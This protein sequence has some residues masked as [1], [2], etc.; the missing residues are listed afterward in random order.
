M[1]SLEP[2]GLVEKLD[3]LAQGR[4]VVG[5]DELN[6]PLTNL[7]AIYP[8][9]GGAGLMFADL[10]TSVDIIFRV[11]HG[12]HSPSN[13]LVQTYCPDSNSTLSWMEF[14]VKHKFSGVHSI[15]KS[16]FGA[17]DVVIIC[18]KEVGFRI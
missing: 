12:L 4:R 5:L 13:V 7:I 1:E 8:H 3:V 6:H 15:Y 10:S 11:C 2:A 17:G 9:D 14:I 16:V 18:E